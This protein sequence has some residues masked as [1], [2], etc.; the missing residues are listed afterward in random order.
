MPITKQDIKL[1]I[2]EKTEIVCTCHKLDIINLMTF[3]LFLVV[4]F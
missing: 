1:A 3:V 4:M 2:T